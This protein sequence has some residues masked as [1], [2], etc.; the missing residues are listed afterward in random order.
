MGATNVFG[1]LEASLFK[2]GPVG[3]K[4]SPCLDVPNGGVLLAIPAL[5]SMGL[6]RHTGKYFQLP[7][8]YYDLTTIFLLLAF[9]ALARLKRIEALRYCAPG[10]WG[11]LL[12]LDRIPEA[13]TLRNKVRILCKDNQAR[14]WAG[15]LCRDWMGMFPETAGVLYIDGHVRVYNGKQTELP[16]HHVARQKL[17]LRATT[18]YW[19][20]AMDGQPFF[21]INKAV[22]PGLL[23][24]LEQEI[25]PRLE[26][27]V[28][29]QPSLFEQEENTLVPRFSLIFDREG[30]SPGFFARM[31]K[32]RIACLTYHK[33]PGEDWP[34]S[35]FCEYQVKLISGHEVTMHLAERGTFLGSG[36]W[37][38]EIRKLTKTGHQTSI[39]ST[40]YLR[41]L[42][43]TAATMFA[44]WSQENFFKYMRE[45]Y[46]LDALG[47]Y[48][49]EDIPE[50]T[51][52]VCP[53]YRE[54]DRDVR[55]MAAQ[56]GRKKCQCN[57]IVLCDEIAPDKVIAYEEQKQALLEE[58]RDME[59]TLEE[60]KEC[61]RNTPKHVKFGDL[62]PEDRF[63]KLGMKSKY[64]IDTVK[65]I[66]YRA[67]TAMANILRRSMRHQDEARS[68]LR[69]L[70]ATE[71]DLLPDYDHSTLTVRL[72]QPANNCSAQTIKKLCRE[73]NEARTKFP[74]TELRL[75]YD[76]VS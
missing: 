36:I 70:Y 8:G 49:T 26:R 58:I 1:R 66:A 6:L 72:H 65:M 17:C 50:S 24:V 18:D 44:R 75:V 22:D 23:K 45:N 33:Y 30:Y 21:M 3:P 27:D 71:A 74:G 14:Q 2:Q 64:F 67:E 25:I 34:Q 47:D 69:S 20:N 76:L 55:N 5:L 29:N 39:V 15:D 61:R 62:P 10:E 42:T 53:L 4:F 32:K 11:K 43:K 60:L 52:V 41:D 63:R 12:G 68:L 28:P 54:A 37:V 59:E 73:L 16:R 56:L 31:W 38:R 13:K 7:R 35:E 57:E 40:D 9:M 48:S 19:V 46:S 51:P